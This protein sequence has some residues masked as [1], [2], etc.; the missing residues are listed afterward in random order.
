[1]S[2]VRALD[3]TQPGRAGGNA[4]LFDRREWTNRGPGMYNMILAGPFVVST[5]R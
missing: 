1:M 5:P 4:L 3:L 2:G